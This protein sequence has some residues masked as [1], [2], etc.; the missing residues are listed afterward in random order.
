MAQ[1]DQNRTGYSQSP[2]FS[3][4][5]MLLASLAIIAVGYLGFVRP[6][7]QNMVSLERQ[8]NKLVIAVKKLQS[9]DETA[10]HGLRLINLLDAQ[11]EKLASAEQALTDFASLRERMM[12]EVDAV[13]QATTAL[14]QLENVRT[15]VD[16]YSLTLT[17]AAKTLSEMAEVSASIATSSEIALQANGSLVRLSEQQSDLGGNITHLG[18]QL[19]VLESKLAN[20]SQKLPQAEQTLVRIDQLCEQLADQT[21]DLSTAQQQLGQLAGLKNEVLEQSSDLQ[22]AAAALDQVWDLKQ[23]LLQASSTISKAQQL[24]VEMMLLEPVFD[25]VTHSL[26]PMAESTRLSRR[27]AA[28]APK[29]SASTAVAE[30]ASPWS[31]AINVFVALLGNSE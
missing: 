17:N 15:E 24:A 3:L 30:T 23:G 22:S 18:R 19:S 20:R 27:E 16:R 4:T 2:S 28:K 6:A 10:R 25:K 14:K 5:P 7:Q 21:T 8:C 11:G 26:L 29:T 13:A 1:Q 31:S 9:R 12:A